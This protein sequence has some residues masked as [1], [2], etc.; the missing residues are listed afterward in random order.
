MIN[1][2]KPNNMKNVSI[3]KK[4]FFTVILLALCGSNVF[5]QNENVEETKEETVASNSGNC[6]AVLSQQ[7]FSVV[8][9]DW[10]YLMVFN[11]YC[12]KSGYTNPKIGLKKG[13]VER[14]IKLLNKYG[15]KAK[16]WAETARKEEVT[17]FWKAL[18]AAFFKPID[19]RYLQFDCGGK[20]IWKYYDN[21]MMSMTNCMTDAY[22]QVNKDGSTYLVMNVSHTN[23]EFKVQT[24]KSLVTTT[25]VGSQVGTSTTKQL[26]A[27]NP[28]GIRIAIPTDEIDDFC[29]K[30]TKAFRQFDK[31]EKDAKAKDK[32]FK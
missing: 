25:V 12:M 2:T 19:V 28:G 11:G 9:S 21:S 30:M 7:S 23:S 16:E 20:T 17:D 31:R 4:I 18:T 24:G 32:L 14:F 3:T 8:D 6:D 1:F 13:A 27:Y 15:E 5:A 29:N 10:G 22:F 26:E